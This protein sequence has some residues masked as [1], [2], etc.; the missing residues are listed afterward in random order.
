MTTHGISKPKARRRR[1]LG[2]AQA[3]A[4]VQVRG[5][6]VVQCVQDLTNS[7]PLLATKTTIVRVYLDPTSVSQTGQI[8]GEL[9]WSRSGGADTFLPGINS[10]RLNPW[11]P[12]NLQEQREDLD[13]SL[14]FRLPAAATAAGQLNLR[15]SRIFQ[16]GG[17]DLPVAQPNIAPV[18]FSPAPTL[19]I[20][21]IG[22]RYKV[23]GATIAPAAVHFSFLRSFLQRAYP[24]AAALE[25]SHIVVDADFS[26]PF[27]DSTVDLANAQIAA[28]R[29]REVSSGVD[30]RTHYYGLVDDN[31]GR[32]F[33][34]G[35]AFAVP[36]TPHPDTVASGPAGVPN[37][38]AGDTDP[39]YADWYGAHE[40]GHTFGRFHPGFPP[41]SQD[42]SDPTFPYANGC[43]SS[44]DN[45]YV[46]VDT[47][48]HELNLPAAALPGLKYH[49]VMT[50]ADN[51]WLSAY[52]Y[53]AILTRLLQE[54]V[55]APPVPVA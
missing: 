28:L 41:G 29:S 43:L 34:R 24:V 25:W 30:P 4:A 38:F 20:R 51:Q 45:K 55:L 10:L 6:E 15:I 31:G 35:K 47:G 7:V 23:G 50:Y 21:V 1:M 36:G 42:A 19:R 2:L 14:N 16:P 8:T 5:V 39:S 9:A 32:N 40:L 27:D 54:D 33:M 46:G 18:T 48:D 13:R 37:G 26:A 53:Q 22:L 49:D 17:A 52:T 3:Q 12:F 44:P 11:S